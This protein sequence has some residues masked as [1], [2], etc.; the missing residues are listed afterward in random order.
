[1]D[2]QSTSIYLFVEGQQIGPFTVN[3]V[4]KL[5]ATGQITNDTPAWESGLTEWLSTG[6][7]VG[8]P[9][10]PSALTVLPPS[11]ASAAATQPPNQGGPQHIRYPGILAGIGCSGF[12]LVFFGIL[13]PSCVGSLTP[14]LAGGDQSQIVSQNSSPATMSDTPD[15]P[16]PRA[17]ATSKYPTL[18]NKN[19]FR[20]YILG[21]S[22]SKFNPTELGPP[23]IVGD[24]HRYMLET[25]DKTVG[26]CQLSFIRLDFEQ[27]YL[28]EITV[29]VDGNQNV[30]ALKDVFIAAYGQPERGITMFPSYV[31]E[32]D[33][34]VINFQTEEDMFDGLISGK[35]YFSSRSVTSRIQEITNEKAKQGATEAA[36]N[37]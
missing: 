23:I 11:R 18:D 25:F 20:D 17:T 12:L 35:A 21:R 14:P 16:A 15:L 9:P 32:G 24:D 13:L 2:S 28:D 33:N 26:A 36:K 34:V 37:L 7:L 27:D 3:Q 8:P 4:R 31:W 6:L 5:I 19:G 1:M 29:G 30:Q 10:L 22:L